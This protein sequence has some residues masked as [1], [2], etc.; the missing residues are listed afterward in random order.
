MIWENNVTFRG[1]LTMNSK[2]IES[3]N[4]KFENYC[5]NIRERYVINNKILLVNPPQFY[6]D[7][8]DYDKAKMKGYYVYPPMGL[9]F[10][11]SALEKIDVEVEICDLNFEVLFRAR[12]ND[13]FSHDLWTKILEERLEQFEPSIV[14][15]SCMF[16]H[17]NPIYIDVLSYLSNLGKHIVITGGPS[18]SFEYEE[19][20]D[21]RL[22]HFAVTKDSESKIVYLLSRILG[23]EA[24][25]NPC[26]GIFYVESEQIFETDG[27]AELP[28]VNID[29]ISSYGLI[30][31]EKY[32][33]AGSLNQY[34]RIVGSNKPFATLSMNRGCR[35]HCTFCSVRA[36]L[37]NKVRSRS[38]CK[39]VSE[40]KYLFNEK[41][42]VQY[43]WL[44][45][46]LLADREKCLELFKA[47]K[48]EKL[49]INW[50]ANNGVMA[51][52]LDDILLKAM[53]ESGCVGFKIGIES[54]NRE[55][56]KRIRKPAT[57]PKLLEVSTA[58]QKYPTLLV[59]GNY[60]IGFP[61]ETF[62]QMLDTFILAN[63]MKLD[64]AGFY[65]CQPLKGTDDYDS[66]EAIGDERC[67]TRPENYLPTKDLEQNIKGKANILKGL[68]IFK[69]EEK[70]T[71]E[72]EQLKEVWFVF[73]FITNFINNK[74]I[75]REG[76]CQKFIEWVLAAME[77][78]PYDA[79]MALFLYLAYTI[80]GDRKSSQEYLMK[81]K[82]ILAIS[83][84]WK[85]R[86]E[87][88]SLNVF[89]EKESLKSEDIFVYLDE[90]NKNIN[91]LIITVYTNKEGIL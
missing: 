78:Y 29:I 77:A 21:N 22:C 83:E 10:L 39:M 55:I 25:I 38:T 14:G 65:I 42:I 72:N 36:L 9:L 74:N 33:K 44:D 70:S 18:I 43:D 45:D 8:Y 50:Y 58:L 61:K 73:G 3:I 76:R 23:N 37:G 87:Q 2:I 6:L 75:K 4:T 89:I 17:L 57:I 91:T 66:F 56:M 80:N 48:E 32:Y 63:R 54:G 13:I 71:V 34:S 16:S 26:S 7:K 88:F 31:I 5:E 69:L 28:D 41:G 30:P 62:S 51:A 35:G 79:G 47:I 52:S 68:D 53:V 86:F 90:I 46:D 64:W 49:E 24:N 12:E 59:A 84:Y 67:K 11:A 81:C 20:L 19:I 1:D 15:V 82:K 60:I 85:D 40:I 27:S